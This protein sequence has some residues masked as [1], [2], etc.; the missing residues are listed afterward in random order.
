MSPGSHV[1]S[2]REPRSLQDSH[3][4]HRQ[5]VDR[6]WDLIALLQK[7]VSSWSPCLVLAPKLETTQ[8]F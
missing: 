7:T 3:T 2:Q 4:K 8:E 1:L 5:A 6:K